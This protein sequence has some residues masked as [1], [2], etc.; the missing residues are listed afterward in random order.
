MP[1]HIA[2]H[3]QQDKDNNTMG[4]DLIYLPFNNIKFYSELF[5]DD[6][7]LSKNPFTYYGNKFAFLSGLHWTDPLKIKDTDFRAEYT[8][9]EPYVYTHTYPINIYTNYDRIIGHWLGPNSDNLFTELAYQYNRYLRITASFEQIRRGEGDVNIPHKDEDGEE[10]HFLNGIVENKK[11]FRLGFSYEIKRDVY[12][13]LDYK[14]TKTK[15]AD[16]I[17]NKN[18][19][20][21]ELYFIFWINR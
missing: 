7:N 21:N 13:S 3:Y 6:F 2:E 14:I 9:I 8:R 5:I 20:N 17:L 1:Y 10:K 11:S 4:F 12:I 15:N 19:N 16:R 18:K